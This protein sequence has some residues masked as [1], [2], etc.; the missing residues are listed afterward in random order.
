MKRY[1]IK[2]SGAAWDIQADTPEQAW[3]SIK[4]FVYCYVSHDC[5]EIGVDCDELGYKIMTKPLDND[6]KL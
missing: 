6:S 2:I 5:Q 4:N 3:E 1:Y